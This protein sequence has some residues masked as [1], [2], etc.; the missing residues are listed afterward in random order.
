MR[1]L[2]LYNYKNDITYTPI[3]LDNLDDVNELTVTVLSGDEILDILYTN[4]ESDQIDSCPERSLNFFDGAY[5]I[6]SKRKGIDRLDEFLSRKDPY[7]LLKDIGITFENGRRYKAV[8]CLRSA[9]RQV[10]DMKR[11]TFTT[12]EVCEMF[13]D[14]IDVIS[15]E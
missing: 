7:D 1:V 5:I 13:N 3:D 12:K 2:Y 10:K 9:K 4:N 8:E 6:Y 14:L 11:E 15:R